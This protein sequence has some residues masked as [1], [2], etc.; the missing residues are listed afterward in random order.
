MPCAVLS[1]LEFQR[2]MDLLNEFMGKNQLPAELRA[3]V[4][5]FCFHKHESTF[6]LTTSMER[7]AKSMFSP[8]MLA[9]VRDRQL[10][11]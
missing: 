5:N 7:D 2:N 8:H 11:L 10:S 1:R 3:R 4:N 6:S 9:E